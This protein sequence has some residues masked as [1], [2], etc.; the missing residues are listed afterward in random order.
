MNQ[1]NLDN[2]FQLFATT[3]QMETSHWANPAT[4]TGNAKVVTRVCK[5]V[6]PCWSSIVTLWDAWCPLPTTATYP[7]PHHR[8]SRRMKK[9]TCR[10][11]TLRTS[12]ARATCRIFHLV[13]FPCLPRIGRGTRLL[14]CT[15]EG[16]K[17]LWRATTE[18][19]SKKYVKLW[20]K[21]CLYPQFWMR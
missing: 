18:F 20:K 16:W 21:M 12:W 15:F 5:G 4:A 8:H 17:S 14:Y 1:L 2:R 6:P 10:K 3:I 13:L 19:S 7:A 9:T 11:T